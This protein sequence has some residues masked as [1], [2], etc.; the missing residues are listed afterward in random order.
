[1]A[2][3]LTY[4]GQ[5]ID[6]TAYIYSCGAICRR[7]FAFFSFFPNIIAKKMLPSLC[8]RSGRYNLKM[9]LKPGNMLNLM[10]FGEKNVSETAEVLN[11]LN[12]L[13]FSE[14]MGYGPIGP[15]QFNMF[16]ISPAGGIFLVFKPT[17]FNITAVG[18]IF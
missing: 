5:D 16:N 10:G 14:L 6:P 2:K 4:D 7:K 18:V 8:F 9:C 11:M 12:F 3:L 15:K 1:M 13:A 17:K